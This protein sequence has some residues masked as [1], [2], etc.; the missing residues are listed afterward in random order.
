MRER[1]V[2]GTVTVAVLVAAGSCTDDVGPTEVQNFTATLT[3]AP[4]G[5]PDT[6][7]STATGSATLSV[8]GGAII[9]RI[10]VAGISN[11]TVA[12]IHGPAA[13]GGSAGVIV[14]FCGTTQAGTPTSPPCAAGAPLTGVLVA[15]VSS[16]TPGAAMTFAR[17]LTLLRT[18]SAYVN[19]HTTTHAGGEIRGTVKAQ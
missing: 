6:N 3:K 14:N 19:V 5:T 15:G 16:L 11:V 8:V 4:I 10:D 9:Y 7:S 12:H 18:D 17:L 2:F 1:M 13:P